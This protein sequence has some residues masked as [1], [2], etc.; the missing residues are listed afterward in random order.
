MRLAIISREE[1]VSIGVLINVGNVLTLAT[2]VHC[3]QK[4]FLNKL[5]FPLKS[6]TKMLLTSNS[7]IRGIFL[8]L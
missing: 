4:N 8:L 7:V 2:G 1:R 5:A 6:L 3:L